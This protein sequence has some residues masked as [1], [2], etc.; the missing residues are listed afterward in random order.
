MFLWARL[1]SGHDATTLLRQA[2]AHN[3]AYVPGAP[4]FAGH[5]DPTTLRLSFTTHTP[6][7]IADGLTRLA[8][9]LR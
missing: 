6:A 3:V 1:P 5:P 2:I 4:F 7:E 9:A 8:K